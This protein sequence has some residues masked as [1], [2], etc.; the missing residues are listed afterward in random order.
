MFRI[1]EEIEKKVQEKRP[2]PFCKEACDVCKLSCTSAGDTIEIEEFIN[3]IRG[4]SKK[5]FDHWDYLKECILEILEED[6]FDEFDAA[7]DLADEIREEQ[8]HEWRDEDED[9]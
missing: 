1:T 8:R 6:Y 9:R 4:L 3:D 7:Y 5:H 2:S